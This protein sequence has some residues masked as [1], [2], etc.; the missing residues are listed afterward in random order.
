MFRRMNDWLA[1]FMYGRYGSDK[2]NLVLLCVGMAVSLTAGFSQL[3]LLNTLAW[4]LFV[5]VIFRMF[6]RN[7]EAR[8]RENQRF[9]RLF[10][11]LRDR[12]NRYFHCPKCRQLVRVPKGKGKINI[13]CPKCGE[14]FVKRT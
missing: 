8:R 9:L 13:H 3:Y 5:L 10:H 6:S 14:Q 1:R 11:R 12:S 4:L 7:I 2:L